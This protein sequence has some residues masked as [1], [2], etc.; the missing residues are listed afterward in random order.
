MRWILFGLLVLPFAGCMSIDLNRSRTIPIE[1]PIVQAD[2]TA[3]VARIG[4]GSIGITA[5]DE[6][7][8]HIE[9]EILLRAGS[10]EDLD[11]LERECE[12]EA[13]RDGDTL[14][15]A[16]PKH[17]GWQDHG[18]RTYRMKVRVGRDVRV[19]ANLS[20]GGIA[21]TGLANARLT[22]STGKIELADSTGAATLATSVG[23]IEVSNHRGTLDAET[24]TG[25]IMAQIAAIVG[26]GPIRC[27]SSVGSVH[28]TLPSDANAD[29]TG[30]TSVG[31][32]V[33]PAGFAVEGKYTSKSMSG[34]LGDGGHAVN[35]ST[36]TGSVHLKLAGS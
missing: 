18:Q 1:E 26:D 19:D 17:D 29:V 24:S 21:A 13:T 22:G 27:H 36:S 31:G 3:F 34:T 7:G 14:R 11:E 35:L 2:A 30:S 12:L 9:Y 28:L 8:V 15:I 32:I 10:E 20:V 23:A 33:A 6:P 16:S 4:V 5:S 25:S